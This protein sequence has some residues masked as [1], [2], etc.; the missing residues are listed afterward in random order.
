MKFWLRY[1]SL[2]LPCRSPMLW[3][4]C[5]MVGVGCTSVAPVHTWRP[6]QLASVGNETIVLAGIGGPDVIAS[7]LKRELLAHEGLHVVSSDSLPPASDIALVS[8]FESAPTD[9]SI[10]AS[11]RNAGFGFMLRGEV[12]QS[13]GRDDSDERLS[14]F[15]RLTDLSGN[16]TGGG[17]PIHV[18]LAMI[19]EQYP[20]LM[21]I[22]DPAARLRQA[23]ILETN[24]LVDPVVR[25]EEVSLANPRV[26][27]G[28]RRI[29]AA[30]A[31]AMAGR[32]PEAEQEWMRIAD[33]HPRLPAIWINS[34]IAAAARQDFDTAKQRATEAVRL[35]AVSPAHA[36][37]AQRTLVWI[38]LR[39]R[40]Y[41]T[42][43]NLPSP[44]GGWRVTRPIADLP[45]PLEELAAH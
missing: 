41:H 37:L 9:M 5:L 34:A 18:N 17:V 8:T 11:A 43:F 16:A 31:L 14:V 44:I 4:L 27:W 30:N 6:P 39:Q 26:R 7:S 42:A 19:Q 20:E 25:K 45:S 29:R 22:S 12:L 2:S 40:E 38:E 13:T 24:G 15:W 28:S 23:A 3:W 36:K 1:P 35:S 10:A 32:W 21:A 33:N